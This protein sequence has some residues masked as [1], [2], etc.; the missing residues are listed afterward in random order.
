LFQACWQVANVLLVTCYKVAGP[1]RF[2]TSCFNN[3]LSSCN[4]ILKKSQPRSE[5]K[6]AT[7]KS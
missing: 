6:S 4:F 5:E 3:L 1:N 2:V 7:K